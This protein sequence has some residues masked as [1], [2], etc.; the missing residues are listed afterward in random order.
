MVNPN[1]VIIIGGGASINEGIK[2]GLWDKLKGK[3]SVGCNATYKFFDSTMTCG[4]DGAFFREQ[5]AELIKLS[6]VV[7]R[8]HHTALKEK[9][10]NMIIMPFSTV[11]YYQG[12]K[13]GVYS[14]KLA[15]LFALSIGIYLIGKGDV[16]LVG[17][18]GGNPSGEKDKIG[19]EITHFYQ[20]EFRHRGTGKVHYYNRANRMSEVFDRYKKVID[21][22]IKNV[23]MNSRI[24]S[25]EKISYDDFL[26]EL[27][28]SPNYE[29][30]G[31]VAMAKE[32]LKPFDFNPQNNIHKL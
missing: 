27:D 7:T 15:G 23:S 4:V 29:K 13:G 18:D 9:W 28:K 8:N 19:K 2:K 1:S 11:E 6:L 10:D 21:I 12:L 17:F 22:N 3:F 25:F 16:Y 31:L 26:I 24:P 5:K 14:N 32:K 20:N 30:E